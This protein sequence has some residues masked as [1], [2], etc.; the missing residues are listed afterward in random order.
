MCVCLCALCELC[1]CPLCVCA[2]CL[3]ALCLCALNVCAL[4]LSARRTEYFCQPHRLR[5][6][7]YPQQDIRNEA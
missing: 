5:K 4:C 7:V 1:Q 3:C 6:H 2:L